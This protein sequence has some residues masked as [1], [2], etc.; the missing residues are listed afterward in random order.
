[1]KKLALDL[2]SLEVNSFATTD[3]Q[4]SR[5]TVVAADALSTLPPYCVTFSCGDSH[6]RPCQAA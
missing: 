5:G 4:P 2:E 1:M 6:F 3:P